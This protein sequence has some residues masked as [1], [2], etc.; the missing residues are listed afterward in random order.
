MKRCCLSGKGLSL[1]FFDIIY[2]SSYQV[3]VLCSVNMPFVE[4]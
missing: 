4:L 1:S 3:N 2:A